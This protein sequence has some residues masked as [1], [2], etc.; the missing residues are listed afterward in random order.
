[1]K[2]TKVSTRAG[3]SAS[4]SDYITRDEKGAFAG[5]RRGSDT[6]RGKRDTQTAGKSAGTH[7]KTSS[8]IQ[9]PRRAVVHSITK[10]VSFFEKNK[11]ACGSL[12]NAPS[13]L[14][15]NPE[16]LETDNS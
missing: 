5:V 1:M 2:N 12:K 11:A 6:I 7:S 10:S 8:A 14:S 4:K 13:D 3:G 9:S 15:Y 16:Y